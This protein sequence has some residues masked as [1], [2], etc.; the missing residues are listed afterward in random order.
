M[1]SEQKELPGKYR[2]LMADLH[3]MLSWAERETDVITPDRL[4]EWMC[5]QWRLRKLH[6]L[7]FWASL[8]SELVEMCEHVRNWT[9]GGRVGSSEGAK[10]LLLKEY[11]IGRDTLTRL[12]A[13]ASGPS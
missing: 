12:I 9:H 2:A 3:L 8:H 1:P 11:S 4:G 10:K 7:L 6:V 13:Q 5:E